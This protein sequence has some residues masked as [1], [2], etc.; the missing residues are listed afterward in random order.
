MDLTEDKILLINSDW[1]LGVT[2]WL[3]VLTQHKLDSVYLVIDRSVGCATKSVIILQIEAEIS[4]L[5]NLPWQNL[6]CS[7][8]CIHAA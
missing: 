7:R 8:F 6:R 5:V 2:T 1:M 3:A 4:G